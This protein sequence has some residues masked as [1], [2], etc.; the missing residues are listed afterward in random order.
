MSKKT[1][2]QTNLEGLGAARLAALLM[3]VSTGSADIKRRLRLELS[4]NLGAAELAHEVRKRLIS[5]RKARSFVSWRKRK[6]LVKDLETQLS[7]IIDKIAAEDAPAAF[8]L[9]WEFVDLAPSIYARV[10]DSRGEVGDVFR[11]ARGQFT[12]IAPRAMPDPMALADRIWTALQD[13][14]YGEWDGIIACLAPALGPEGLARLKAAVEAHDQ[15]EPPFIR[16]LRRES[17]QTTTRKSRLIKRC[18]QEIATAMGDTAA[19][20]SQYSKDDLTRKDIAAEVA[21]LLVKTKPKAALDLLQKADQDGRDYGQET[22][23]AAYIACLTALGRIDD[24]Q[25]HRWAS[26]TTNLNPAPLRDYLKLLPDFDDIEAEGR[27]K[28]H[29]LAW[30]NTSAALKF[31][32]DWPDL[33]TAAQL[34][35]TRAEDINGDHY[36]LLTPLA[37]ALCARHPRAAVLLWR[38]MIDD[39]LERARTSRYAHAA[40][41]LVDCTALDAEIAEYGPFPTHAEYLQTLKSRHIRKSSFW[42]QV[43]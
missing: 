19:Y 13:N 1:L 23:D 35:E 20:I 29:V 26:F 41:H 42:A 39:T 15:T 16:A 17:G 37:E 8:D 2:N 33:L 7:M 34:I 30:P 5:L 22:W 43:G 3:E 10:D 21:M 12:D 18:L 14:S 9:L 27:A 40:S 6:A 36:L 25:T 11:A 4:H 32:R 24:A 28:E 31:C 38:A